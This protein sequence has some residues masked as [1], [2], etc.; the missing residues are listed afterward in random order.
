[1]SRAD[2]TA[3]YDT[4]ADKRAA[5]RLRVIQS[6]MP[7]G[8]MRSEHAA[9]IPDT[10]IVSE[11]VY[12]TAELMASWLERN[13]DNRK[14]DEGHVKRIMSD[15][16]ADRWLI[17]HQGIAF[18]EDGIMRD[19]QH[20][21]TA[22]VRLGVDR[23][24]LVTRGLPAHSQTEMDGGKKRQVP[25]FLTGKN[26]MIRAAGS[27][28]YLAFRAC[29]PSIN[30]LDVQAAMAKMTTGQILE[31]LDES[32][33]RKLEALSGNAAE[34]GKVTQVMTGSALLAAA[35]F[36]MP[37]DQGLDFLRGFHQISGMP[38]GDPRI[39]VLKL[40]GVPGQRISRPQLGVMALR[41]AIAYREGKP[42]RILKPAY[43]QQVVCP[44]YGREE[45][46]ERLGQTAI[47]VTSNEK[48]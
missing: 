35:A 18:D 19:G 31:T 13:V 14:L 20:R 22:Q 39:A 45:T 38:E 21:G 9:R 28:I 16:T 36:T 30:E 8:E 34:A 32:T 37:E 29:A 46:S 15:M 17:T 27:R 44:E 12:V 40:R 6:S 3:R 11:W 5:K 10:P 1:M 47:D 41:V 24:W 42:I 43:T 26:I 2:N 4:Q 25:D 23:W 7:E 33:A 48:D